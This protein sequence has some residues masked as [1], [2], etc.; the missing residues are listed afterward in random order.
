MIAECP[1][2][3]R[4]SMARAGVVFRLAL[5]FASVTVLWGCR[6]VTPVVPQYFVQIDVLIPLH[7]AYSQIVFQD[8][9]TTA[10]TAS[11]ETF[12][13]PQPIA[14]KPLPERFDVGVLVPP[15]MAR[16]REQRIA[17]DARRYL[18]LLEGSL[19]RRNEEIFER[20]QRVGRKQA[21]IEIEVE[22]LKREQ[23]LREQ[24]ERERTALER[25]RQPLE[26]RGVVLRRQERV[27]VGMMRSD[28]ALQLNQVKNRIAAFDKQL[29]DTDI[30]KI[31][32]LIAK[33]MSDFKKDREA[34][35][36]RRL[37]NRKKRLEEETAN[38][39]ARE[40]LRLDNE[41]E[42]IP[43]L[44]EAVLSASAPADKPLPPLETSSTVPF[45]AAK[46]NL[47]AALSQAQTQ[48]NMSRIKWIA[49]L[50]ADTEKAVLQIAVRDGWKLVQQGTPNASNYTA[51]AADAL[52]SQWKRE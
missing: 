3:V 42:S 10:I 23:I 22:R 6:K 24:Y 12:A 32:A 19:A 4:Q 1:L 44:H 2:S 43:E 7:P 37:E 45:T 15:S 30:R 21:A 26:V 13:M 35:L 17:S 36:M 33:G 52:K 34:D 40:Q 18:A 47:R 25:Q 29:E 5:V 11:A 14:T 49:V 48:Q 51:Q 41:L 9:T 46:P 27:W 39:I 8:K 50:R 38:R 20:E 16:E 28:A 31:P